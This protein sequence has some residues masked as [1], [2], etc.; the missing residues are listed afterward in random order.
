MALGPD[1][2]RAD[3][4][5]VGE[6]I[7]QAG[8]TGPGGSMQVPQA[9]SRGYVGV[10]EDPDVCGAHDQAAGNDARR[11]SLHQLPS[12]I[13][14]PQ[15]S[16]RGR[17]ITLGRGAGERPDVIGRGGTSAADASLA[18]RVRETGLGPGPAIPV[19]PERKALLR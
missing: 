11:E 6:G 2:V 15:R 4:A 17:R 8:D 19:Q 16:R 12:A 7:T 10:P 14:Q 9:Y 3:R 5:R 13:D 1:V 18:D